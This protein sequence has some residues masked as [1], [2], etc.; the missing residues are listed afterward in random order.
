MDINE[1]LQ[2]V[3]SGLLDSLKGT[4]EQELRGKISEEVVKAIANTEVTAIVE[5]IIAKR[6]EERVLEFN[7]ET[8][9]SNISTDHRTI[10]QERNCFCQ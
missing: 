6:L 8:T 5:R 10:K 4:I 9:R 3:V 2:P 7:I 1:Q